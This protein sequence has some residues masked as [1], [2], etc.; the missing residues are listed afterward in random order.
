VFNPQKLHICELRF[1]LIIEHIFW[2]LVWFFFGGHFGVFAY[3][4]ARYSG[5]RACLKNRGNAKAT[6]DE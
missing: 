6:G 4:E 1:A 5:G 2:G 3:H